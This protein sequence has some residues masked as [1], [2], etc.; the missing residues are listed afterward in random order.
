MEKENL[1]QKI[2]YSTGPLGTPMHSHV[3]YQIL[4]VKTGEINL[5]ISSKK[6]RVRGP[7][8]IFISN[9]ERHHIEV[10]GPEYVRYFVLI[11]SKAAEFY[12]KNQRLLSAFTN[13]PVGFSH[14][15]SIGPLQEIADLVFEKLL[16]EQPGIAPYSNEMCA[17]LLKALL[18]EL[19]RY[20]SKFFPVSETGMSGVVW[21]IKKYLEENA[22][23]NITLPDVA[24][25]FHMSLYYL[26]H[27]FKKI[28]GY[29]IKQYLMLCRLSIARE[30]LCSTDY[31]II[32]IALRS[33]FSDH[34]NFTRYFLREIGC[35][36]SDYRKMQNK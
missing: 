25:R 28:T 12:I 5:D 16:I 4:Y 22:V 30:L 9:L 36:P 35:T 19:Y 23:N 15:I 34:S 17:L 7:S 3:N 27:S 20:N 29:S 13:R 8:L 32:E 11:S 14:V 21:D 18:V 2:L 24:E 10:L 33:G 1:I 31:N 26:S 6:Y